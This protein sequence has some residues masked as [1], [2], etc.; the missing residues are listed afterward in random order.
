M[1]EL[2]KNNF[3]VFAAQLLTP[4]RDCQP[5]KWKEL[6]YSFGVRCRSDCTAK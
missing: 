2:R 1:A 4:G 5:S 6:R 3:P